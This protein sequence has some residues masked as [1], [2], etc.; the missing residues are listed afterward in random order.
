MQRQK[1]QYKHEESSPKLAAQE[2]IR[3]PPLDSQCTVI[4]YSRFINLHLASIK[5]YTTNLAIHAAGHG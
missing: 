3:E 4:T 1:H 2:T 5:L